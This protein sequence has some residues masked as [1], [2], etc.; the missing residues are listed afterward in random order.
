MR[1]ALTV[2]RGALGLGNPSA[3]HI[4]LDR[5]GIAHHQPDQTT[6]QYGWDQVVQ[7]EAELATSRIPDPI[8]SFLGPVAITIIGQVEWLPEPK[9]SLIRLTTAHP[10]VKKYPSRRLIPADTDHSSGSPTSYR[11][12]LANRRASRSSVARFCRFNLLHPRRDSPV[13]MDGAVKAGP[14]RHCEGLSRPRP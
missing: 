14:L 3:R 12:I 7:V 8:R 2:I 11:Q 5:I 9:E 10:E 6:Q 1:E 13:D 4:T